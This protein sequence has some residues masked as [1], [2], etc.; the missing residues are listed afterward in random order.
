MQLP[1]PATPSKGLTFHSWSCIIDSND[2][3]LSNHDESS[4]ENG[5]GLQPARPHH[6]PADAAAPRACV[7]RRNSPSSL[8]EAVKK[9]HWPLAGSSRSARHGSHGGSDAAARS[10]ARDMY[11]QPDVQFSRFIETFAP[12][13]RRRKN[14]IIMCCLLRLPNRP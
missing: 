1:A 5:Y 11:P 2:H 14:C 3:C 13:Y 10:P 9:Y 12:Y 8:W 6:S 4:K 7:H